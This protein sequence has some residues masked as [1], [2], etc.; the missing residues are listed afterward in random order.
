MAT[1]SARR[2]AAAFALLVA[3]AACTGEAPPES[4]V[5]GDVKLYAMDCGSIDVADMSV[6]SD[7]G[8]FDGQSIRLANPCFLVRHPKGNLLWDTGHP[9]ELADT[10]DGT[11]FD[12]WHYALKTKLVDQLALLDLKPSDID[13]LSLSHLH[14]DHSGNAN[15][16]AGSTFIINAFERQYMFSE[17]GRTAFGESYSSL[18]QATTILFEEEHDVFGDGTIVMKSMP[19]HTPGSSVLLVRL[20]NSGSVLLTGD[21]YTHAKAREL[22]TVPTF[23]LDKPTILESRRRFEALAATENARVVIQ[24]SLAAFEALPTFPAFLD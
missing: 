21:L 20:E 1:A 9:D 17:E 19:G 18:E 8:T 12:V 15:L 23:N 4:N 24:H 7:D 11:T 16:F 13:Y 6:F 10:P 14:P 5:E 3:A 2:I 22:Q